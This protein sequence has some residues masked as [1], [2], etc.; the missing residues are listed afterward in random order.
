MVGVGCDLALLKTLMR[1]PRRADARCDVL[2]LSEG[3]VFFGVVHKNFGVSVN[4]INNIMRI[5]CL[6]V[7]GSVLSN[8]FPLIL[9]L[10]GNV[11]GL[12]GLNTLYELGD[13]IRTFTTERISKSRAMEDGRHMGHALSGSERSAPE[14][15]PLLEFISLTGEGME[16]ESSLVN[17][18]RSAPHL[19]LSVDGVA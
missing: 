19:H 5:H 16:L 11:L 2:H 17:G 3:P 12:W 1:P 6:L 13:G 9:I 18:T 14:P 7:I 4:V 15:V 8:D 10:I